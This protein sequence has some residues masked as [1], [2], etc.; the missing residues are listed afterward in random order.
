MAAHASPLTGPRTAVQT[1]Q[2]HEW[3]ERCASESTAMQQEAKYT[4]H[5]RHGTPHRDDI[6]SAS[7][8]ECA[9]EQVG[10]AACV[11]CSKCLSSGLDLYQHTAPQNPTWQA[12]NEQAAPER[13]A[14]CMAR[15]PR[16]RYRRRPQC[17]RKSTCGRASPR[18]RTCGCS[19]SRRSPHTL[20]DVS[21]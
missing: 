1:S 14:N 6:Q 13:D 12:I 4:L 8:S 5:K 7:C 15:L 21:S 20:S 10:A 11:W 19:F 2:P 16:G 17:H 18:W 3:Q 9:K